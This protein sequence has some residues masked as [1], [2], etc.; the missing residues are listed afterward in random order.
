MKARTVVFG[1]L[2]GI[3]IVAVIL[4]LNGCAG[5]QAITK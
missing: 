1:V 3:V 2:S 4:S 5:A